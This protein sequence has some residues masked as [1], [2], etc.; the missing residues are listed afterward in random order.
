MMPL[1]VAEEI[2]GSDSQ[3]PVDLVVL[4]QRRCQQAL[5]EQIEP[6]ATI[7]RRDGWFEDEFN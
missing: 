1:N 2:A 4:A 3:Y 7:A 6:L 5:S